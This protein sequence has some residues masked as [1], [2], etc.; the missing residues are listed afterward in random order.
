[1]KNNDPNPER[2]WLLLK[3]ARKLVVSNI[4]LTIALSLS[5]LV[6]VAVI[7]KY[8]G[9]I[10]VRLGFDGGQIKI[11]GRSQTNK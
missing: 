11:D 10:E 9:L 1:M 6:L 8:P 3:T 2:K 5:G 4:P 7:S